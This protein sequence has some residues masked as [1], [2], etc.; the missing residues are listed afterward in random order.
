MCMCVPFWYVCIHVCLLPVFRYWLW[1]WPRA[2]AASPCCLY[3][4]TPDSR[5]EFEVCR[6]PY[7]GDIHLCWTGRPHSMHTQANTQTYPIEGV[8]M[9]PSTY[10]NTLDL[11]S[12]PFQLYSSPSALHHQSS[13]GIYLPIHLPFILTSDPSDLWR[14]P[15]TA[16]PL[17]KPPYPLFTRHDLPQCHSSLPTT[18]IHPGI[19]GMLHKTTGTGH[20]WDI[21]K[22]ITCDSNSFGCFI[23]DGVGRISCLITRIVWYVQPLPLHTSPPLPHEIPCKQF[24]R[25]IFSLYPHTHIH[26]NTLDICSSVLVTIVCSLGVQVELCSKQLLKM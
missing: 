12:H 8:H 22:A 18:P 10:T 3:W 1:C 14:H 19:L 23:C 4:Q 26:I 21:C 13:G 5:E 25:L 24:C 16:L 15:T 11:P 17:C 9:Q 2:S 20:A 7:T 6:P